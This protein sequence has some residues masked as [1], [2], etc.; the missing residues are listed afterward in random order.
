MAAR[1]PAGKRRGNGGTTVL[2][3]SEGGGRNGRRGKKKERDG[4][5]DAN[6]FTG[7]NKA[8]EQVQLKSVNT[9]ACKGASLE[10]IENSVT[11]VKGW[12]TND[13]ANCH[14][15]DVYFVIQREHLHKRIATMSK[16]SIVSKF[17]GM[18]SLCEKVVF[19]RAMNFAVSLMPGGYEELGFWP[20]TWILPDE[21]EDV[22]RAMYADNEKFEQQAKGT[23]Q[24]IWIVKPEDGTQGADIFLIDTFARLE[25][26]MRTRV[27]RG[28]WVIQDYVSDPCLL[29]GLKFDLRIYATLVSLDPVKVYVCKEGLARFCT[30]VYTPPDPKK[31]FGSEMA[32]LTNYS[33]N[34]TSESF[35]HSNENPFNVDN[36]ASKRPISTLIKQLTKRSNT[37]KGV[38]AFDEE[39]FW[40]EVEE[41]I[42]ATVTSMLPILRV[43]YA[44]HFKLKSDELSSHAC[45]AYHLL[46]VD[47]MLREDYSPVLL[48]INNSPSLNLA[49]ATPIGGQLPK[50]S[51]K[52]RKGGGGRQQPEKPAGPV[53]RGQPCNCSEMAVPHVHEL[54]I[55]DDVAKT[56]AFGGSLELLPKISSHAKAQQDEDNRNRRRD[57]NGARPVESQTLVQQHF[58]EVGDC[59]Q[60]AVREAL[61]MIEVMYNRCGG[62]KKGFTA[63]VLRREFSKAPGLLKK[64]KFTKSD[65][66]IM[67]AK[68]T[69]ARAH[70]A[71]NKETNAEAGTS[72]DV[73][74]LD[75]GGMFSEMCKKRYGRD[76]NLLDVMTK[77]LNKLCGPKKVK[78]PP[79]LEAGNSAKG[80]SAKAAAAQKPDGGDGPAKDDDAPTEDAE[81]KGTGSASGSQNGGGEAI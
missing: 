49:Q 26:K 13:K 2:D 27:G 39:K 44:R 73:G 23:K 36:A 6:S 10:C 11:K 59:G 33:L 42:A 79:G 1:K 64:G 74:V 4:A 34:K 53:P 67:V 9:S 63:G 3:D 16:Q 47:I 77:T 17:P 60:E 18:Y 12:R 21:M 51:E 80:A 52:G 48:E 75:W 72:E 8:P 37:T 41:C 65:L 45:Q 56:L 5:R 66:D 29:D 38:H 28:S 43:S 78:R 81:S 19:T 71:G 69:K 14:T 68:H 46:G 58:F 62:A 24:P 22:E 57:M 76:C 30:E 20:R 61:R 50:I 54:S 35:T 25:E 7:A 70:A 40:D 55:V 15:D 31:G 32:H